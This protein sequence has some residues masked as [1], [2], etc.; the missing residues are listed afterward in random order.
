MV[1]SAR[2]RPS[3]K[4]CWGAIFRIHAVPERDI[5]AGQEPCQLARLGLSEWPRFTRPFMPTKP[6]VL[7]ITA[8]RIGDAVLGS[9]LLA[10]LA[11]T[12]PRARFTIACGPVVAPLFAAVPGLEHILV[13]RKERRAGGHW[14][15]LWQDTVGT[16]WDLVV[17]LRS[18]GLSWLLCAGR[19]R[20]LSPIKTEEHRVVRM[21]KVLRTG[22]PLGPRIFPS[23]EALAEAERRLPQAGTALALAPTANWFGKQWPIERFIALAKALAAPGS[24]FSEAPV[25]VLGGPGEREAAAPLLDAVPPERRIDLVGATDLLTAYAC[26]AR[27]R[28]FIGNDSGL[29]HLAAASGIPTLGLF[30]PSREAL[31]APWGPLAASIRG[32]PYE[33]IIGPGFDRFAPRSYMTA[34]TVDAVLEAARALLARSNR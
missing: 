20:I 8:T 12:M 19:R 21:S 25:L 15:R 29:M 6:R 4:N 5:E 13:M 26:L 30:G 11:D 23:V 1:F 31:Y 34:L 24:P 18:S 14:L 28:L 2:V 32:E 3:L 33:T 22:A 16:C 17:D 7:F 10:H 9:G 27:S